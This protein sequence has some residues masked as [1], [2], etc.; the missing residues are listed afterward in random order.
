MILLVTLTDWSIVIAILLVDVAIGKVELAGRTGAEEILIPDFAR[1]NRVRLKTVTTLIREF[2]FE[3]TSDIRP[4]LP[5]A[6][7]HTVL[8]SSAKQ[9]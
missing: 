2:Q 9:S 4:W 5:P 6:M 3:T 1:P 8:T 7:S